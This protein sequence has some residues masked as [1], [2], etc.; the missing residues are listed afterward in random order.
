M[1]DQNTDPELYDIISSVQVHSKTHSKSC[2]KYSTTCRFNFP[3]PPIR[4]T[5][6]ARAD[7]DNKTAKEPTIKGLDEM[8][9]NS[10]RKPREILKD[11]WTLVSAA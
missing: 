6:I 8:S 9:R 7:P 5:F 2:K 4:K 11:I 10:A 1:P 3:R